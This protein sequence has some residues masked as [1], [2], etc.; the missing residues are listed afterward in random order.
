MS[1]QPDVFVLGPARSGTT[2]LSHQLASHL[3]LA[4]S[5]ETNAMGILHRIALTNRDMTFGAFQQRQLD[6]LMHGKDRPYCMLTDPVLAGWRVVECP[7][8]FVEALIRLDR[9][10][11]GESTLEQTPRNGEYLR[12]LRWL[13][14]EAI[15]VFMLRNPFDVIQSNRA[16]PWGTRNVP[17]LFAIW[18]RQNV[19]L[20]RLLRTYGRRRV[21]LVRYERLGCDA[22]RRALIERIGR[23][24]VAR[25][26]KAVT[27]E[28][29]NFDANAWARGHMS[30]SVGEFRAG[31]AEKWTSRHGWLRRLGDGMVLDVLMEARGSE[32]TSWRL[33][34]IRIADRLARSLIR[35]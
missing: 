31:P 1:R 12:S 4:C 33:G 10:S 13:F 27:I 18:A 25:R 5:P 6:Y 14:P 29:R 3:S 2:V 16:T 35:R 30:Q 17:I 22:Y 7:R 26:P 19:E 20:I 15:I 24:G 8:V 23:H 9:Y 34:L 21:I 28:P 32:K 11:E